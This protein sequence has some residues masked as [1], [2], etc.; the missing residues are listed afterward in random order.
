ME[1][2]DDFLLQLRN[3]CQSW[4]DREHEGL[5]LN[6][7]FR[8]LH[9]T[10]K[11]GMGRVYEAEDLGLQKDKNG[12]FPTRAVKFIRTDRMTLSGIESFKREA[13]VL[14]Q[15]VGVAEG[16]LDIHSFGE[17]NGEWYIVTEFVPGLKPENRHQ[18]CRHL[19]DLLQSN[20]GPL[21]ARDAVEIVRRC[22]A[23]MDAIHRWK[24]GIQPPIVHRDLKP[25]NI[26]LVHD[27][28]DAWL[29]FRTKI[30][31]FGLA[32]PIG[33]SEE[34]AGT[35][36]YMAPEQCNPKGPLGPVTPSADIWALGVI[37]VELITG[38]RPYEPSGA[39]SEEQLASQSCDFEALILTNRDAVPDRAVSDPDLGEICRRCLRLDPRHRYQP[40]GTV[41]TGSE[42][43][44]G[45]EPLRR[46]TSEL[47]D[48][49]NRWLKHEPLK[50][51][52]GRTSPGRKVWLFARR[53][54]VA[55]IASILLLVSC[56]AA[57]MI[58]S[59]RLKMRELA[60]DKIELADKWKAAALEASKEAAV[61]LTESKRANKEEQR[62]KDALVREQNTS[63]FAMDRLRDNVTIT[64][65][66]IESE[67]PVTKRDAQ[68]LSSMGDVAK[69][70]LQQLLLNEQKTPMKPGDRIVLLLGLGKLH[71]NRKEHSDAINVFREVLHLNSDQRKEGYAREYISAN[72]LEFN[73][74]LRLAKELALIA[75]YGEAW[76]E[77]ESACNVPLP[78]DSE[79]RT[80]IDRVVVH[81]AH[82]IG[83]LAY[84]HNEYASARKFLER[85]VLTSGPFIQAG[86]EFITRVTLISRFHLAICEGEGG[87]YH[88]A[89][90]HV[91]AANELL[92]NPELT[93]FRV[94]PE[95]HKGTV[96]A[97]RQMKKDSQPLFEHIALSRKYVRE[98]DFAGAE[99]YL[100]SAVMNENFTLDPTWHYVLA[101][102]FCI[103]GKA[104]T[105][106]D[107][108][109]SHIIR[110]KFMGLAIQS[111]RKAAENG[112]ANRVQVD[113]DPSFSE[114]KSHEDFLAI[115]SE[116]GRN[117]M[118]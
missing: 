68:L 96:S 78:D 7:R 46:Q 33:D 1:S 62:A 107:E 24:A 106:T 58:N 16:V 17:H 21:R 74:R 53:N 104:C 67:S 51:P 56:I 3:D 14:S 6:D 66:L 30:S 69:L 117:A 34:V 47:T 100:T 93:A 45:G 103:C 112:Y 65:N 105:T 40:A 41:I 84:E 98:G 64:L 19:G 22:A 110:Q 2:F 86:D 27:E 12:R 26:L 5:R 113:A 90:D 37:L 72:T 48:A 77:L 50:P 101:R 76:E 20:G 55:T 99:E 28:S 59:Q 43:Q 109:L 108:D 91:V 63:A 35:P 87:K 8:I 25:S 94:I 10:A 11:G 57:L 71:A 81:Q 9:F 118:K 49:L 15:L 115:L 111:L 79:K 31:D 70:S 42:P 29:H 13:S 83:E 88:N 75:K 114:L 52:L 39:T 4:L 116:I 82:V 32:T 38:Q 36:P 97:I 85:S 60:K 23:T 54:A 73:T 80:Q 102:C 95:E 44:K 18:P 61:A 89:L 92:D